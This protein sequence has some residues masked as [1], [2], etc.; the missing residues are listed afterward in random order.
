MADLIAELKDMARSH[1]LVTLA[2]LLDLAH[3][4]ARLRAKDT[5]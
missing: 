4:E 3:S 2:G 1:H 5:A